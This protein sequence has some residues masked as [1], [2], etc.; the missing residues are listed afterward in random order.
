MQSGR[1]RCRLV[2]VALLAAALAWSWASSVLAG[3]H[4]QQID[5]SGAPEATALNVAGPDDFTTVKQITIAFPKGKSDLSKDQKAQLQAL[6]AQA[7]GVNGYMISVVAY[8]PSAGPE[9]A[10]QRLSMER[11][12]AVTVILQQNGVPPANVIVPAA[13]EPAPNSTAKGAN[14]SAV[15]TLLQNKAIDGQ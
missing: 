4:G 12:R 2:L 11:A 5:A 1:T 6:A 13:T 15:V 7:R 9:S 14:R 8:A 3:D 10:N